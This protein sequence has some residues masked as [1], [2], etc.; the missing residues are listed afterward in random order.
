MTL[1]STDPGLR[2][3][4]EQGVEEYADVRQSQSYTDLET[5]KLV[6]EIVGQGVAIAGG[7]AGILTFIRSLKQNKFQQIGQAEAD[8]VARVQQFI[9]WIEEQAARVGGSSATA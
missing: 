8:W 5:I 7:V 1:P 4:V 3:E 2:R 9:A 6:L